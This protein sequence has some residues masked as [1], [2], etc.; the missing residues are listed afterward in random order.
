MD[1]FVCLT[2]LYPRGE[3]LIQAT[4]DHDRGRISTDALEEAYTR[5][6][7]ALKNLQQE[8]DWISDGLLAWQ[9][10][11]RPF[12]ELAGARIGALTR[13]FETNTFFRR[14]HFPQ[15]LPER[16]PETWLDRYFRF[17]NHAILPS[18]LT[19]SRMSNLDL[20]RSGK[21][22]GVVLDALRLRGYRHVTWMEGFAPHKGDPRALEVQ[23]P[24]L[25][26]LRKRGPDLTFVLH[27]YFGSALP[28][29]EALS[30]LPVDGVGVDLTHTDLRAF[31]LPEGLG[32][33]LGVVDTTNS[34][35]ETPEV[36]AEVLEV[37]RSQNPAF[38]G[39]TGS[40]DFHFLPRPVADGK[41]KFLQSLK[42]RF[43]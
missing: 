15:D 4:R 11:V 8:G 12:G 34:L 13:Y 6:Y 42:E 38:L 17:G 28:L 29:M 30:G 39:L 24:V 2:G 14:L 20:E 18:P 16:V 37:A 25:E 43:A 31:R 10:L 26:D 1:V 36:V 5:D 23:R 32:L 35:M 9:D 19:L 22:L 27:L 40:A 33:V 7:E 21:L 3:A 41:V